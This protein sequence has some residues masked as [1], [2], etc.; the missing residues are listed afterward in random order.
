ME[1]PEDVESA[2]AHIVEGKNEDG[3]PNTTIQTN[4]SPVSQQDF[5]QHE[6]ERGEEVCGYRMWKEA[7]DG[8]PTLPANVL[9][10]LCL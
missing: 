4:H 9:V 7:E 3:S 8:Y 10:S 6:T 1:K 2:I 5:S